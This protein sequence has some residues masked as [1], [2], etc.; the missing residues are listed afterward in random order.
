M[1]EQAFDVVVL[2]L[3]M[4]DMDGIEVLKVL[5][6]KAPN[7]PVIM[8]T[9]YGDIESAR[10]ARA[11]GAFDYLAKPCDIDVLTG[12]I[13]DAAQKTGEREKYVEK[14]VNMVMIPLDAY[15]TLSPEVSVKEAIFELKKSFTTRSTSRIMETG[16]RSVLVVDAQNN[17]IGIMAILDLLQ[18]IMPAYLNAPKPATADSIQYSP[19]FWKGMFQSEVKNNANIPIGEIMSP[20]PR[21]ID[22]RASLMEATY[23]MV[24]HGVRRLL[25]KSGEKVVGIIREQ[26]LFFEMERVLR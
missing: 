4:E 3:K 1:A 25:V 2:D 22:G 16:H 8:L 23:M 15:T 14:P 10:M 21:E 26:D 11:Q 6:Q 13:R 24:S 7:L 17:V 18:M 5:K 19:M 20:A 12:K 9:G